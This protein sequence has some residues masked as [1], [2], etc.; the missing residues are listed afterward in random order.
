MDPERGL[1]RPAGDIERQ[2]RRGDPEGAG[3]AG[4]GGIGPQ[5]M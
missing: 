3:L 4:G 1:D 5:P 2:R